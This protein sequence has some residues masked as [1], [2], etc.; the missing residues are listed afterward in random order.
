LCGRSRVG[1]ALSGENRGR[2]GTYPFGPRTLPYRGGFQVCSAV[3]RVSGSVANQGICSSEASGIGT[4]NPRWKCGR[5]QGVDTGEGHA[6]LLL[7]G[8][9]LRILWLPG[10]HTLYQILHELTR[11]PVFFQEYTFLRLAYPCARLAPEM[12]SCR[13]NL[14]MCGGFRG[15]QW[16]SRPKALA[17]TSKCS[18]AIPQSSLFNEPYPE[19]APCTDRVISPWVTSKNQGW[20]LRAEGASLAAFRTSLQPGGHF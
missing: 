6:Y 3:Q 15:S 12:L 18:M 14:A 20:R 10:Y 11:R 1:G 7:L 19:P 17:A 13:T 16:P 9:R 2:K 5:V 4:P 8:Y